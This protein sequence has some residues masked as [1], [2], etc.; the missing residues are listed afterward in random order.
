M[1]KFTVHKRIDKTP[2]LFGLPMAAGGLFFGL[3]VGNALFF[4]LIS[5][6]PLIKMA[7]L[8]LVPLVLYLAMITFFSFFS[9]GSFSKQVFSKK[10]TVIKNNSK[11]P[12]KKI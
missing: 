11:G 10:I 1:K 2:S 7:F 6:H 4:L 9:V 5:V 12:F 8:A 3:S